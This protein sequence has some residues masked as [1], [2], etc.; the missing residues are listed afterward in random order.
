MK[1]HEENTCRFKLKAMQEAQR[2]SKQRAQQKPKATSS[3]AF[4]LEQAK[5]SEFSDAFDDIK[6]MPEMQ[7]FLDNMENGLCNYYVI[8]NKSKTQSHTT[9]PSVLKLL[10]TVVVKSSFMRH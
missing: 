8:L 4:A 1:G 6:E 2:K 10:L 5:M 7:E 9:D 3:E